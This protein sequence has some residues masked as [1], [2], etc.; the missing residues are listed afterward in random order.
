M[1]RAAFSNKLFVPALIFLVGAAVYYLSKPEPT[2]RYEHHVLQAVAFAHGRLDVQDVPAYYHDLAPYE[3]KT[4]LPFPPGPA[5]VLVPL[6]AVWRNATSELIVSQLL[7]A[8]NLVLLWLLLMRYRAP[9]TVAAFCVAAFGFGSV[10]W[11]TTMWGNTWFFAHVVATLFLLAGWLELESRGR[12]WL[13]GL[14]W[15]VA[16][17]SRLPLLLVT[18]VAAY[19]LWKRKGRP[20]TIWFLA[21]TTG[22]IALFFAF[23]YAR[24]D[25]PLETGITYH[26]VAPYFLPAFQKGVFAIAHLP[27]NLHTMLLRGFEL[28]P[29][30]PFFK[31]SPEGLAIPLTTPVLVRLMFPARAYERRH[32]L[33][34]AAIVAALLPSLFYF[35]T[36]WVQWGF[37]YGLDWLP[38]AIVLLAY[39]LPRP[40]ARQ[41]WVLLGVSVVVNLLGV[42]WVR[43]LGW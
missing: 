11:A 18:P 2:L 29:E 37:R 4:Y 22:A 35:S 9:K 15:A 28:I 40:P 30:A 33:L 27:Q 23:N 41:D 25:D 19:R 5:L 21:T 10:Y 8:L 39:A 12:G 24:F 1:A 17:L 13:I 32:W 16:W 31:P 6:A 36:G 34:V 42:Y 14:L 38:F 7:G 26:T 3:G 43:V 20:S